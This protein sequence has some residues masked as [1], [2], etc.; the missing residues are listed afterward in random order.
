MCAV[1]D[2]RDTRLEWLPARAENCLK[3]LASCPLHSDETHQ[4]ASRELSAIK[5]RRSATRKALRMR[6]AS[7]DV[8]DDLNDISTIS[9][10]HVP[11]SGF[12]SPLS[13][14]CFY[15]SLETLDNVIWQHHNVTFFRDIRVPM[16]RLL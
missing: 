10:S 9:L 11:S 4:Q 13:D 1:L 5:N 7:Q 14:D 16:R 12:A 3:H 6:K 15:V 2:G 8:Q